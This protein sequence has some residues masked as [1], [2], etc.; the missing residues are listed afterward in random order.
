MSKLG[1]ILTLLQKGSM[2]ADPALWKGRQITATVLT[3]LLWAGL[4]LAGLDE[5]VGSETVDAI[6]LGIIGVSN[7]ILTITTTTKIGL[8]PKP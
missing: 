4:K 1:A 7:V 8:Q 3:S 5:Q 6:A 2:V